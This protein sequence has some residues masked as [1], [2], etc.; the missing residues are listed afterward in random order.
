MSDKVR[1]AIFNMLGDIGGLKLLDAFAGSGALALEAISRGASHVT[2]ID[3]DKN[4][5]QAVQNNARSL[6]IQKQVKAIRANVGSWSDNNPDAVF[7]IVLCDPPYDKLRLPLLAKLT[8]H[9]GSGGLLVLSWPGRAELPEFEDMKNV[10]AKNY[11]DASLAVY[12]K[13]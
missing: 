6:G 1:G 11:G 13:D 5:H 9:L 2:A 4:A 8:R 3:I 12:R 7:D 10:A